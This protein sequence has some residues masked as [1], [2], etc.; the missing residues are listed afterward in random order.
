[1]LLERNSYF[2]NDNNVIHFMSIGISQMKI[3]L[4]I[5][6][7]YVNRSQMGEKL[8]VYAFLVGVHGIDLSKTCCYVE[9]EWLAL[10]LQCVAELE[11]LQRC[12]HLSH[13]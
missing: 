11:R 13:P 4:K 5:C 2:F 8:Q 10:L 6:E 7:K 3:C 1:M 9:V 12:G